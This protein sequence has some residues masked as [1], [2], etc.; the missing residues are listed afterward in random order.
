MPGL[1]KRTPGL[2]HA[3]NALPDSARDRLRARLRAAD[4][5][6]EQRSTRDDKQ[7]RERPSTAV[8]ERLRAHYEPDLDLLEQLVGPVPGVTQGD[9]ATE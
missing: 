6:K 3:W 7:L 4:Y 2:R 8:V 9:R 1:V 5:R